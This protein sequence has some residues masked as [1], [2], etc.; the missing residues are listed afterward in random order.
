MRAAASSTASGRSS[1]RAQSSAISVARLEPRALAEEGDGLGVGER[2]DR[3]LDL[4]LHAQ[5]LAARDEQR[6]V[7]AGREER[8]RARAPPRSPARGCRAGAASPARRCARRGRSWRPSVWAIVSRH[9]RGVAERGEADPEDARLVRRERASAAASSASRVLPEPPGP[10]SV[11]RRAPSS[12]E[13]EHVVRA[14]APVPTNEL[15]GRGRF[16]FEIV[17]S[18][19]KL[20]VAELEDRD[21]S[22][23]VLQAVLAEVGERD[24][25]E[26]RARS[27]ARARPGRRARRR[28]RAR[29]GGR[30]RRRSP[31]R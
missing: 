30:R 18:G 27:P 15:A 23:D 31:R 5:E 20:L 29:R 2:R 1:R 4:A 7:G 9:E 19:G 28:R 21:G 22:V 25:V 3:V 13:R 14:R 10:V 12:S 6:E 26:E 24:A 16:V 17:L 11:T 8:A